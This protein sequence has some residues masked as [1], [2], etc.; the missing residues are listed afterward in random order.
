MYNIKIILNSVIY[1]Y[2]GNLN[3][4]FNKNNCLVLYDMFTAF[5]KSYYHKRERNSILGP[6]PFK[7]I[8]LIV[9]VNT[10]KQ[11]NKSAALTVDISIEIVALE[12]LTGVNVFVF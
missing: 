1:P 9:V 3:L 12:N 8:C 4:N 7:S 10:L 11:N 5:K 6:S 2:D